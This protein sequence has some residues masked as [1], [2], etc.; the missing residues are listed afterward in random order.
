MKSNL[1]KRL[2]IMMLVLLTAGI[3]SADGGMD[4]K[5]V[6]RQLGLSESISYTADLVI[7]SADIPDMSMKLYYKEGN[8]RAEGDQGGMSF[9]TITLLDGVIYTYNSAMKTWMKTQMDDVMKS[10]VPDYKKIG[11]VQLDGRKCQKFE[12]LDPK[13][14]TVSR[15]FVHAGMIRQVES[16]DEEGKKHVIRYTNIK[17]EK[18]ADAFFA[19]DPGA[20]VQDLTALMKRIDG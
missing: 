18:L 1:G 19:P 11:T 2:A 12:A 8:I 9:V 16:K 17:K 14:K 15:V 6:Y 7:K 4:L 20:T 13:T 3:A 10:D 5:S